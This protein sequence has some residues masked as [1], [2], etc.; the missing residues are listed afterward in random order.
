MTPPQHSD[1]AAV[2]AQQAAQARTPSIRRR[3]LDAVA[4]AARP[5]KIRLGLASTEGLA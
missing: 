3:I 1:A 5:Y 2:A 4:T